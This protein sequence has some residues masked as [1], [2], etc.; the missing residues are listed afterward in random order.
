MAINPIIIAI[1][2]V[3]LP[4]L[5]FLWRKADVSLDP[6]EPPI[7]LPK[8]PFIG[9]IVGLMRYQIEYFEMLC[10]NTH[11][12]FTLK[13]F[14][15]R[16]YVIRSPA[17]VALVFR[18]TKT[19]SFDVF[20]TMFIKHA[21]DGPQHV[22]DVFENTTYL[23]E[24]HVQMY[25]ALAPGPDLTDSNLRVLNVLSRYL[26][27]Q[28]TNL[29]ALLR[30][31]YTIAMGESFYGP[32]NPVPELVDEIWEFEENLGL[33]ML[34]ISPR[35][36]APKAYRGQKRLAA[37]FKTYYDAG[38]EIHGNSLI[39]G[40]AR[41]ARNHNLDN[42][43]LGIFEMA[44]CFAPVTNV[45]P[46]VFWLLSYIYTDA[47]LLSSLRSELI[48]IFGDKGMIDVEKLKQCKLLT[49]TFQE[50]QRVKQHGNAV[51]FVT[52]DTYLD[53]Y[54]LKKGSVIQIPSAVLHTSSIWGED[55][56]IFN[57][58]RFLDVDDKTARQRG[59]MPFGGGRNLCPGRHLAF[60]E[61]LGFVAAF[62][63]GFEMRGA[64]MVGTRLQKLG[65][66][67]RKPERDLEV[68]VTRREGFEDVRWCFGAGERDGGL[69]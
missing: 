16:I 43:V 46:S 13:I 37:K 65:F 24:L 18:E 35:L 57:A 8:I 38:L 45:V 6:D 34:G 28:T 53:G 19:L 52:A 26:V 15:S 39:R 7:A 49:S 9:H 10:Q 58:R 51:R 61:A 64:E 60:T 1:A 47:S 54:L 23:P 2:V 20:T 14:N 29:Y 36:L 42:S 12:I 21:L 4:V 66:G 40:R 55:A 50:M 5:F 68:V 63:L 59:F 67:A 32:N 11:P 48:T 41:V 69:G 25:G 30:E 31:A 22:I 62:V 17:H 27:P 56:E 33:M 3:V 44:I